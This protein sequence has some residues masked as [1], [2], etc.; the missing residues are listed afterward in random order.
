M[1][2]LRWV[3]NWGDLFFFLDNFSIPIQW[4]ECFLNYQL[5]K[6]LCRENPVRPLIDVDPYKSPIGPRLFYEYYLMKKKKKSDSFGT[7][8][9][10]LISFLMVQHKKRIQKKID[11]FSWFARQF[12]ICIIDREK[13]CKIK[14]RIDING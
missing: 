5:F 2:I 4:Y 6:L 7:D 11:P 1:I 10:E 8:I 3:S 9:Q 13:L 14:K 12:G